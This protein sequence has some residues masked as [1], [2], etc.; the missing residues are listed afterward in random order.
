[1]GGGYGC[2]ITLVVPLE[3]LQ[4]I[5]NVARKDVETAGVMLV[6]VVEAPGGDTRVLVRKMVWV[7]ES[8]YDLRKHDTMVIRPEG[9]IPALA[10]AESAGASCLWVHTHPGVTTEPTPG[11]RDNLVDQQISGLFRSRSGSPY[12]GTLIFSPRE[13]GVA[14]TGW[15][16]SEDCVRQPI[17]RIWQVGS[18]FRLLRSYQNAALE[19]ELDSV[20]ELFDRNVRAFGPVIQ[21][22]LGELVVG[23]VGCGG[24]GSI[25][26]EQLVRLGVRKLVLIDPKRLSSSNLTR[27]YGSIKKD[28]G[29][30]KVEIAKDY[31]AKIAPDLKCCSVQGKVT[32]EAVARSLIG[33][34]VIFGCTDDNAGRLVLSRLSS[35][36]LIPMIDCGVL[37]SSGPDCRLTGIDGRVTVLYPG[38][39]C[40]QCRGRV[41]MSKAGAEMLP[42]EDHERL[43]NEGYA[44]A[45]GSTE[46]SVVPFTTMV[47][48][49]AV[50]E[51]LE[52]LI[53]YGVEPPPSEILLRC[54]ER[55]ISTNIA[56]SRERHF[57]HP[58][59]G[60]LGV[61][62]TDPFLGRTWG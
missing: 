61:G 34:D 46:P 36:M 5:S 58:I 56:A 40:L 18:R 12:Y 26:A 31:L 21:K 14:F 45:L 47:G 23:V 9:Y 37:L 4:D 51:L 50:G 16:Q 17:E 19:S 30:P 6:S 42:S 35:Y 15:L 7:D 52:R 22:V 62:I 39:A 43:V 11:Y 8:A 27:V 57:C 48:A 55:E 25:V 13:T 60:N 38:A 53:G 29:R 2:M 28:V 24:T 41:D 32:T 44:P 33:C 20:D 10:L 49:A 1:M 3:I 59:N 54:H